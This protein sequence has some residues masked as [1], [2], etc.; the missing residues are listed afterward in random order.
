MLVSL[1]AVFLISHGTRSSLVSHS[2]PGIGGS[3]LYR[4]YF[5]SHH[6]GE[7]MCNTTQLSA[8]ANNTVQCE[9]QDQ[10]LF[11][12]ITLSDAIYFVGLAIGFFGFKFMSFTRYLFPAFGVLLSTVVRPA[13]TLHSYLISISL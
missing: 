11:R 3:L 2:R 10:F 5:I 13:R 9:E 4:Q 6:I 8:N 7:F 1:L 12:I